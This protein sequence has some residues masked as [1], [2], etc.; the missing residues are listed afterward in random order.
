MAGE[1]FREAWRGMAPPGWRSSLDQIR[2]RVL[3]A[4]SLV[5]VTFVSESFPRSLEGIQSATD[6]QALFQLV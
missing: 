5:T 1:R 2:A 6:E 3:L 4:P